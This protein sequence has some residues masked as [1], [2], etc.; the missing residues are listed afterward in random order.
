M[1]ASPTSLLSMSTS[2]ALVNLVALGLS[3]VAAP[4]ATAPPLPVGPRAP[5]VIPRKPDLYWSWDRIPTSFQG[6]KKERAFNDA[7]VRRLAKYQ[8]LTLEK[9]YTPCAS[10]GPTQGGPSCDVENRTL[11]LYALTKAISPRYGDFNIM[12]HFPRYVHH[13]VLGET[14]DYRNY[15]L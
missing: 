1:M 14:H 2:L 15:N 6:A 11:Q 8:M 7:E 3:V 9:W 13:P 4:L 12:G 5:V 10:Q